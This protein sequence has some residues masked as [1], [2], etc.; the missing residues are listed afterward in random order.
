MTWPGSPGWDGHAVQ[1]GQ[2]EQSHRDH[3]RPG[4]QPLGDPARW[5]RQVL[6]DQPRRRGGIRRRRHRRSAGD[7]RR[8]DGNLWTASGDKVIKF[9]AANPAGFTSY[10]ATGVLGARW[11]TSGT[12]GNLWVADFG[13]Q[14][15]VRVTTGG[16]GTA[17]PTGG[18]P[19]G[20]VGGPGSQV[21]YSPHR[22]T[23]DRRAGQAP[24]SPQTTDTPLSD[25]SASRTAATGAYWFAQFATNDLGRLTPGGEYSRLPWM[26]APA[27]TD[28]RRTGQHVVGD[29]GP[30]RAGGAG[31]RCVCCATAAG[32]AAAAGGAAADPHHQGAPKRSSRPSD[33]RP[34]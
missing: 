13:G 4:R 11:I 23:A 8:A 17:F 1:P 30:H 9:P 5:R 16:V 2:P 31:Q 26:R 24:G 33:P 28:H 12:D 22:R 32:A 25:R 20:V 14:Q 3:R 7:H 18:G 27:P 29:P 21:A 19:Q 6:T 10:A 15:I 34:G